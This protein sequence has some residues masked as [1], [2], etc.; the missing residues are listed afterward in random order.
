MYRQ[1]YLATPTHC[2]HTTRHC[3]ETLMIA[4]EN[5]LESKETNPYNCLESY[6][7]VYN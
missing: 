1:T 5:G 4:L 6:V 2:L 3:V 7:S